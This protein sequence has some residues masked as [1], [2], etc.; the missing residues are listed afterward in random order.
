MTLM[1][2]SVAFVKPVTSQ[3]EQSG[4]AEVASRNMRMVDNSAVVVQ[5]LTSGLAEL[6]A[7]NISSIFVIEETSQL[8]TSGLAVEQL[9]KRATAL[10]TLPTFQLDT[11]GSS[12]VHP[13]NA[14]AR[15]VTLDTSQPVKSTVVRLAQFR[16]MADRL[17]V[18]NV[19][20]SVA[21][22]S[23]LVH[24]KKHSAL[25]RSKLPH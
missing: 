15:L 11:S 14:F 16:N 21:V 17:V 24:P 4:S 1:N 9:R 12:R 7:R 18:V 19:G 22:I 3:F 10:V 20:P 5:P 23:R 13:K 6:A 2:I 8:D 25:I